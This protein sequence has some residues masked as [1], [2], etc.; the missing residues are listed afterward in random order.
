MIGG[1]LNRNYSNGDVWYAL[2]SFLYV[3]CFH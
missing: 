1:A 2:I 3:H